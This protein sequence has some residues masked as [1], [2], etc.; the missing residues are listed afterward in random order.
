VLVAAIDLADDDADL[1]RVADR[2]QVLGIGDRCGLEGAFLHGP[3]M[4]S[5]DMAGVHDKTAKLGRLGHRIILFF[6]ERAAQGMDS[7]RKLRIQ[8]MWRGD[9]R[10]SWSGNPWPCDSWKYCDP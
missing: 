10:P 2:R 3:A 4:M 9:H 6:Q 7:T 5:V 8:I 1:V